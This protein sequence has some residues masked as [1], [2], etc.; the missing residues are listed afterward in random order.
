MEQDG[1]EPPAILIV[2]DEPDIGDVVKRMIRR[3]VPQAVVGT[4]LSALQAV[5]VLMVQ[6]IDVVL[7]DLRMPEMDGAHLTGLIKDR[8][9]GT[10]V[11][12]FSG[13]ADLRLNATAQRVRADAYLPKPFS[14][15]ELAEVL[16]PLLER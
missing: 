11:I 14:R 1:A 6:R 15:A 7:T 2:D 13:S 12:I 8:W 4:T 10:R 5:E 9:P 3:I 16:L